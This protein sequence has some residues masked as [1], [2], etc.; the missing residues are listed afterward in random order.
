[1]QTAADKLAERLEQINV[2]NAEIPVVQNVDAN[3]H[4]NAN[5]IKSALITQLHQPVLWVDTV[6]RLVE[7]GCHALI[8]VGP[9]KVLSGLIKRINRELKILNLDTVASFESSLSDIKN[10]N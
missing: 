10:G 1:M 5:E 8:E 2:T 6:N 9:G 3:P 4:I 7:S